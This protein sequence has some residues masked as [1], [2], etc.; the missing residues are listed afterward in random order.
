MVV[1]LEDWNTPSYDTMDLDEILGEDSK[2]TRW[3]P[4][5]EEL[6]EEREEA[7]L[8]GQM[9]EL[10]ERMAR[11]MS[12]IQELDVF[13]MR[14]VGTKYRFESAKAVMYADD[15]RKPQ[16]WWDRFND[17]KAERNQAW[18]AYEPVKDRLSKYWDHWKNLRDQCNS[19]GNWKLW[20][21]YNALKNSIMEYFTH[22]GEENDESEDRRHAPTID[23]LFDTHLLEMKEYDVQVDLPIKTGGFVPP[24]RTY[25]ASDPV[26]PF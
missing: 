10:Q 9:L 2:P 18:Q 24:C 13:R 20:Q 12:M 16:S 7:F 26:C 14:Y 3:V 15:T 22:D 6:D 1:H 23:I 17:L 19:L 25:K 5:D 8:L 21:Q 11:G 4:T